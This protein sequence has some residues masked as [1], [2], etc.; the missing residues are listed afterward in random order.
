L[1]S[2]AKNGRKFLWFLQRITI[3]DPSSEVVMSVQSTV[4]VTGRF[5]QNQQSLHYGYWHGNGYQSTIGICQNLVR[6]GIRNTKLNS[7]SKINCK[8]I[9]CLNMLAFCKDNTRPKLFASINRTNAK[10]SL[11]LPY[12]SL[13]KT[14]VISSGWM[15]R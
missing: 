13:L 15:Q 4:W 2:Q 7:L 1:L 10:K 9:D 12:S 6:I 11:P 3:L 8:L 14:F 5:T